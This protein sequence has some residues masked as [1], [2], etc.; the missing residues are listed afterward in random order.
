MHGWPMTAV[1]S[2]DKPLS[3]RVYPKDTMFDLATEKDV[4]EL[5]YLFKDFFAESD[6][7]D[8]G[9]A[10][11]PN[12]AAIWL[13][14]VITSGAFPHVIARNDG[15]IVGVISWSM[16]NSFCEEP[17]A[18]LHTIFVR[19]EFRRSVIGRHLLTFALDIAQSEGAC[20][21]TAPIS[22]GMTEMKSLANML[23]KAGFSA[24]GVIM[25]RGF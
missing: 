15:K 9:I 12:N 23:F 7:A 5:T 25:T 18:V 1:E 3:P 21:F 6:Y 4:V 19:K 20:C 2:N 14:R 22:S 24:S 17:I 11:S 10:Y 16:D 8:K 13:R